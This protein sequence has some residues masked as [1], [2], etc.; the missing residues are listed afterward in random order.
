MPGRLKSNPLLPTPTAVAGET[1]TFAVERVELYTKRIFFVCKL[2][3]D[4]TGI[5]PE[6]EVVRRS[7]RGIGAAPK[8]FL[9]LFFYGRRHGC[10][11][12][13]GIV[14]RAGRVGAVVEG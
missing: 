4:V 5:A 1:L 10:V 13:V 9:F 2:L 6:R 14:V 3:S 8:L 12:I 11:G 7:C